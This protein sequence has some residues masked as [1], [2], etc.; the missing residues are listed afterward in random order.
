MRGLAHHLALTDGPALPSTPSS[1]W[2]PPLRSEADVAAVTAGLADGT[3]DAIATDHAPH[4][5][6]EGAPVRKEA[7]PGM[8]RGRDRAG[9]GDHQTG[10]ARVM[11]LADVLGALS[12]RPGASPVS[13]RPGTACRRSRWGTRPT[14]VCSIHPAEQ[15]VVDPV[16]WPAAPATRRSRAG[17]DRP[18]PP[19]PSCGQPTVIDRQAQ[20][21]P[22]AHGE[23]AL[24]LAIATASCLEGEAIGAL[25]ER[26]VSGQGGRVLTHRA[27]RLPGDRHRPELRG[28]GDRLHLSPHRQL[29]HEPR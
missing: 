24:V 2:N 3:I 18:G 16:A 20:R 22:Q 1:R 23:A 26:V 5:G 12:W 19:P 4:A 6:D 7:P 28:P 10:R 21:W 29:R 9:G 25:E 11:P 13:T 14:S 17:A 8:L 27:L 15:W